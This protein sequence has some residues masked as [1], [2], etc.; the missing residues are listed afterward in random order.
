MIKRCGHV[1]AG[2]VSGVEGAI[3]C[4]DD[5]WLGVGIEVSKRTYNLS[6]NTERY[7]P[8]T[9]LELLSKRSVQLR[10]QKRYAAKPTLNPRRAN[11][12]MRRTPLYQRSRH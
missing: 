12:R 3:H 9:H 8:G 4:G 6:I 7:G 2:K 10:S 11:V 5:L 1:I